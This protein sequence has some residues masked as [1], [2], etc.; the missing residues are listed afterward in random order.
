M[1][2][3]PNGCTMPMETASETA[4]AMARPNTTGHYGG[5]Y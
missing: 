3:L 4:P 1:I 5:T 2:R